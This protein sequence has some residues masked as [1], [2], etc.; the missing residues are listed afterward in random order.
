MPDEYTD[1]LRING[2]QETDEEETDDVR[3]E[4]CER[5]QEAALERRWNRATGYDV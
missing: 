1:W 2:A 5:E 4:R 3:E